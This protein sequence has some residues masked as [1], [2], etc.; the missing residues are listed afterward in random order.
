MSV[1]F[2]PDGTKI[3][4]RGDFDKVIVFFSLVLVL[5]LFLVLLFLMFMIFLVLSIVGVSVMGI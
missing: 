5:L 4:A 1:A 2:S 3:A